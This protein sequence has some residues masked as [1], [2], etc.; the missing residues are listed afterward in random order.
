[1]IIVNEESPRWLRELARFVTI[2]NLLFVYGN[3]HDLVSFP[4]QLDAPESVR[5]TESDLKGFFQ[6]FLA[7]LKYE[8]VAW[9]DA[10]DDLAFQSAEM[11]DLFHRVETGRELPS[12]APEAEKQ[13]EQRNQN[14][15]G[16]Q[17][18]PQLPR[19]PR[20]PRAPET[21]DW[22]RTIS[23]IARGLANPRVP[24]AF[25]IDLASRLTSSPDR[26]TKDERVLFTRVLKAAT[27]SREVVRQDGRWNNL[28]ILICDKMNDLPAFLYL[29]NPCARS[30][31]IELPDRE[32]RGRFV[33]R[34]YRHFFGA[35]PDVAPPQA[36]TR[37]FVDLSEGLTNYE[38][39]SL[40]TLS[41]KEHIPICEPDTGVPNVKRISEMYKYG[42]TT[43]EWDKIEADKL[44][45]AEP[46]IRS[47]IKGQEAAVIRVLDIVKRAKIGLAAGD[48]SRSNR[49]RGVLFFAGPTGVGKT[50]M[51]K[52][53]AA[54]LFG[55]EERLIRFD[56]S[57]YA[58][59][60]SDQRLLGAPPG[61]VGY[62]E[63]G[64]LTNAVKK[65]PF[66]ILLFDEIEKAHA[67]I[68]DKFLQILD[69]GRLTDGK[70]ETIYF[71]ECIIIFTSNLGAIA[72]GD[73]AGGVG[74]K[75]L[76]T[77]D[78]PYA[79]MR[80]IVL[81]AI[82][83]HFNFVLGRPE[84]L[85]RFG[86]NFVVFDFIKPPLDEQIV[87]LL[88]GKLVKAA[89]EGK[90]MELVV[91]RKVRDAL[92]TLAREHLQH[93]GRG[94]RNAI[95][96]ALVNPLSRVLFDKNVQPQARV[97][98]FD[99]IDRGEEAATRFELS[100]EVQPGASGT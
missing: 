12:E 10:V 36:V 86:D 92:V 74:S 88:I 62:E 64:Q 96:Y 72:R 16:P 22:N 83:D 6:R 8:V 43:S 68:F 25:V 11:E 99:L 3:V 84:I 81:E 7:G 67:S 4:I 45:A 79:R 66:A 57:E 30:I 32:E 89:R 87:D 93:G 49:P 100:V 35:L 91:E 44:A 31:H 90:K 63:G 34:Y 27:S 17:P 54:L 18:R 42:V 75:L 55:Q 51:A 77:P 53:L 40:V 14:P 41:I 5:W 56:M 15:P 46:F 29:N 61:Y 13:S 33:H 9:A 26:L 69:D 52:A 94:I 70:G 59:P 82:R 60:Q 65:N 73:A 39:R 97:R 21:A 85:N 47:R 95:D 23:R 80:D 1:M 48:S 58:A 2:K 38:M 19:E 24:C 78:M 50:E 28:L 37:D 98:V 76:V 71:S 20:E